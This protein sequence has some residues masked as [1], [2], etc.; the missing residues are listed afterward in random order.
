MFLDL[1][2]TFICVIANT[3]EDRKPIRNVC[4]IQ[5]LMAGRLYIESR[6]VDDPLHGSFQGKLDLLNCYDMLLLQRL[7]QVLLNWA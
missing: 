5:N 1:L 6:G 4:I 7:R 2:T 3:L